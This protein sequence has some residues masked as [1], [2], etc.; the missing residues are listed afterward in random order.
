[1]KV[2][3]T[4]IRWQIVVF[5][6]YIVL[7]LIQAYSE[8][9]TEGIYPSEI[10]G[11]LGVVISECFLVNIIGNWLMIKYPYSEKPRVFLGYLFTFYILF[12]VYR[13]LVTYPNH[14][15]I[16]KTYNGNQDKKSLIFFLFINSITFNITFLVAFGLFSIKKSVRMEQKA[17]Q[18]EN[19]I[20]EAQL[21]T[22]KYQ[23]NPHFLY[24]TLSY[25]YAQ[26]SP[27]SQNLA[28]SILILSDMMRYSLNK[29]EE[30]G[31]TLLEK[32]IEYIENFIEIHR[33]RFDTDFYVNFEVEGVLGNKKIAPLI[34]I[35]FVENAIKHG[36]INDKK[37]PV[38]IRISIT[39]SYLDLFVENH[40]QLGKKDETSGIGLENTKK[41]L[42]L[43]Y[44]SKHGLAIIDKYDYFTVS[45]KIMLE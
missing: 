19:Q 8:H 34:L 20:N 16:L 12:F 38:N 7:S 36:R 5:G 39:K 13:Y 25:M 44:P 10:F 21:N 27:V 31:S 45:L 35:T 22:L 29:T 15:D 14:V 9:P 2:S 18:L 24:N 6:F 23:I 17:R 43:L 30:S 37:H 40:K 26:A 28:K 32:E 41:R 4:E 11:V 33:L 1:M 42:N 3:K